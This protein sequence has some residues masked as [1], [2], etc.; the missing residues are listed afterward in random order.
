MFCAVAD[1]GARV[2]VCRVAS[3]LFVVSDPGRGCVAWC[4]RVLHV[5][6][7]A[8]VTPCLLVCSPVLLAG[9]YMDA[10]VV[11]AITLCLAALVRTVRH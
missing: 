1:H 9:A 11:C 7:A 8:L 4:L 5:I 3:M 10:H 2:I 6:C